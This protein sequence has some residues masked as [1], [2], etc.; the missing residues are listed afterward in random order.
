MFMQHLI[1]GWHERNNLLA[2]IS[3]TNK[4]LEEAHRQLAESAAQ[5]QELA[6]LRERTRLAREMHDTLGHSLALVSIKLEVAHAIL[7]AATVNWRPPG[8]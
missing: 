1:G 4:E 3:E 2:K 7:S 6:V 5:E 8:R